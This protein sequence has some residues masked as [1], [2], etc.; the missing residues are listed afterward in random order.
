[1]KS[2]RIEPEI[3]TM[4]GSIVLKVAIYQISS[5]NRKVGSIRNSKIDCFNLKS[6]LNFGRFAG[7]ASW[8]ASLSS[9]NFCSRLVCFLV[10]FW[11]VLPCL[12]MFTNT[13]AY[14]FRC[15]QL[16]KQLYLIAFVDF[17]PVATEKVSLVRSNTVWNRWKS[18]LKVRG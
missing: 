16:S 18:T 5:L 11:T 17:V 10:E 9:L 2:C 1:M 3:W 14:A 15:L 7:L 4:L 8:C 6:G 12:F 13:I